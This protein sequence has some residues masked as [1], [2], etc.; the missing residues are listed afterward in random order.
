MR[1]LGRVEHEFK[2]KVVNI[3]ARVHANRQHKID[4][5]AVKTG[6][7]KAIVFLD[8]MRIFWE[9]ADCQIQN[10]DQKVNSEQWFRKYKS[11][12]DNCQSP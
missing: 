12:I 9:K 8:S 1:K 11:Q 3:T 10:N 7:S 4:N 5:N 6:D 2:L